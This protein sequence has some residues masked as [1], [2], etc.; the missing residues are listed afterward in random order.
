M[1]LKL[2]IELNKLHT[3]NFQRAKDIQEKFM[4][5]LVEEERSPAEIGKGY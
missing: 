5:L 2:D 3:L 4:W 1:D